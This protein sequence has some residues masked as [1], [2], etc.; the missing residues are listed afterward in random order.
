MVS[1]EINF[2]FIHISENYSQLYNLYFNSSVNILNNTKRS[3]ITIIQH[4]D[5][6]DWSDPLLTTNLYLAVCQLYSNA[7]NWF[8]VD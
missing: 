7:G 4:D 5:E 6:S 3:F 1:E 2:K 8:H